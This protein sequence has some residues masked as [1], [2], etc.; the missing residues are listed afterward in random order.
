MSVTAGGPFSFDWNCNLWVHYTIPSGF[1]LFL[2]LL[3]HHYP[4]FETTF[5]RRI[6]DEG[7]VPEMRIC[8]ILLI[9]PDLKCCIHLSRSLFLYLNYLVT[10][11]AGG[12]VN[13][14][15]HMICS[16]V[17]RSTWFDSQRFESIKIVRVNIDW[18]CYFVALL[19]HPFWFQLVL[20]LS[21][22]HFPT[23][24]TTFFGEVSMMRIQDPKCAYG[25]YC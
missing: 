24:E 25:P 13:T 7:S 9:K 1:S 2:A 5:W 4:T 17:L 20:A 16:Q 19:H 8:S 12:T 14:W 18:N 11:T 21:G 23:F 3:G 22:H 10:V 15:G 6:T